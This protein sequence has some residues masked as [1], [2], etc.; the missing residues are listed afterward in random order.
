MIIY[1]VTINV[2]DS[3]HQEWL[4]WMREIHVP[5]VMNTGMF[6]EYRFLKLL[7]DQESGG[8][9]YSLQYSCASMELYK[10]YEEKYASALQREHTE[11]F[12]DQFIAFRTLLEQ[13]K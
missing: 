3:V 6:S 7:G 11:K 13:V 8:H 5:D 2:D 12:R 1:S 4:K 9:T 10:E